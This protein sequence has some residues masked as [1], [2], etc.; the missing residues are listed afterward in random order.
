MGGQISIGHWQRPQK[1]NPYKGINTNFFFTMAR[2][3]TCLGPDNA[4]DTSL[5]ASWLER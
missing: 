3:R 2:V 4:S 1:K 5:L